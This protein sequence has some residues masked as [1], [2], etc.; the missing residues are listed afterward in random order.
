M[1]SLD[2]IL[3]RRGLRGKPGGGNDRPQ[4]DDPSDG[5]GRGP[6]CHLLHIHENVKRRDR[7][8]HRI[9]QDARQKQ[10]ADQAKHGADGAEHNRLAEEKRPDL[11]S[12]H[13]E[14]A[15][16][17][18]LV[19]PPNDRGRDGIIYEEHPDEQGHQAHGGHVQLETT[20]H[21]LHFLGPLRGRGH[22]RIS[23]QNLAERRHGLLAVAG[24]CQFQLND[25]ELPTPAEQF[26]GP[27]EIHRGEAGIESFVSPQKKT[28]LQR[29]I[30]H[31]DA[32]ADFVAGFQV[33]AADEFLRDRDRAG[34]A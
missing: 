4:A 2:R 9:H 17:P 11:I 18:D 30:D 22:A 28:D 3:F 16:N 6:Q 7:F 21:F 24:L 34:R 15:Q 31:A 10:A 29:A 19:V 32:R 8:G 27:S 23:R 13:A 33:V 12:R 5:E 14:R 26:L 20:E 25:A 1:Q